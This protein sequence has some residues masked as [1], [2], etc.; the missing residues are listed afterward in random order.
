MASYQ[1]RQRDP[2][3]DSDTQAILERRG[4]ELLGVALLAAGVVAA[5]ILGSYSPDDPS[6]MSATDEP[7]RNLWGRF[8]ASIASPLY[9]ISGLGSWG[10]LPRFSSLGAQGSCFT[11]AKNGP[12]GA[13]YSRRSQSRWPRSTPRPT[14]QAAA[15]P[16]PLVLAA[17]SAIQCWARF[18]AWC[19]STATL[20]LKVMALLMALGHSGDVVVRSGLHQCWNFDALRAF[21]G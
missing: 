19:R 17:C 3:L 16:T 5:M 14:C 21:Y 7:A 12:S 11:V 15:G 2:L 1:A 4:K 20:G 13:S 10:D 8:G 9:I 6:W 18:L